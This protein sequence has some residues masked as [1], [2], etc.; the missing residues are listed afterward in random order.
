MRRLLCFCTANREQRETIRCSLQYRHVLPRPSSGALAGRKLDMREGEQ[1]IL[2]YA[3]AQC[4]N[5]KW[6]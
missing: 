5:P 2:Q 4:R 3:D 1:H 6:R